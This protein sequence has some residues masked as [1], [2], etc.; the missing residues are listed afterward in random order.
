MAA[1]KINVPV[2]NP[3]FVITHDKFMYFV[4]ETKRGRLNV[5]DSQYNIIKTAQTFGDDPCHINLNNKGNRIVVT[6][7]SSGSFIMY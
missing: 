2:V 3:S 5:M 7:Y 1:L 6:N 4:E